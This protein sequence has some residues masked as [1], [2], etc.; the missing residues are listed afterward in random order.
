VRVGVI[1]AGAM[2]SLYGGL[3]ARA[4]VEVVLVDPW[5]AHV[6]AIQRGGLRLD[7]LTGDLRIPVA[8]T[9]EIEGAGPVDVA[10]VLTD[11]NATPEA[12]RAAARC[13][14]ADGFAVTLQNGIGNVEALAAVLGER[15]VVGG[16]S[17][18]SAAVRGP[19]H[20][21]HTHA[22]PTW[23]G[24][25][26]GAR[27]RR[28]ERLAAA[29]AM[30]GF[31]PEIVDDIRGLIWSKWVHNCAI[32]ALCAVTGLRVG[33]IPRHAGADR[34]QTRIIE[35]ALAVVRARGIRLPD[36]D[37]MATIKAF[38]RVKFNKP[39]MLQ[40]V[41]QGK[42]TEVD[43][44]NGALVREGQALGIPT[45]YNEALAWLTQAVEQRMQRVVHGPPVD[46]ER[47]EAEAKGREPG[48]TAPAP[49]TGVDDVPVA[50]RR[51]DRQGAWP[52]EPG[53]GSATRADAGPG[54]RRG[55]PDV[56]SGA[57]PGPG[58]RRRPRGASR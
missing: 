12:A 49:A 23:L 39:S 18:H 48:A 51:G 16:L 45:P 14:V 17:Y 26:D 34:L 50:D 25:L 58:T 2:G 28:V 8:A 47:L 19:G 44:L 37:P 27:S 11:A 42:R 1:G 52:S 5:A 15:R 31:T 20:V 10:V 57:P 46:Y 38:C 3:L 56:G 40:H 35:E 30:A 21:S 32:N 6:E 13:L 33:E 55:P 36:P 4:G 9:T 54:A 7:G 29:L 41:E 22:G 24:E 43:A 53:S